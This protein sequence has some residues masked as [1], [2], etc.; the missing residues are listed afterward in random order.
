MALTAQSIIKRAGERL[1]DGTFIRWTVPEHC[2]YFNDGQREILIHRP[3]AKSTY[4]SMALA[5]GTRQVLPANAAKLLDV[6]RNTSGTK[7]AIRQCDR[8]ILDAQHPGWHA[9]TGVTE[10]RHFMFDARDPRAFYVYPPAAASGASVE[11]LYSAYTTDIAIPAEG[12]ELTAVSGNLDLPDIYGN[13]LLDYILFRAYSKD[14]EYAGNAERAASHYTLF[15][16]ALGIELKGT[17]LAAPTSSGNPNVK[18]A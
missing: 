8:E 9:Y 6:P 13:V 1:Q 15:A 4:A 5:A 16:N 14:A 18:A 12:S 11:V 10:I 17:I 3:D 2:G 7:R